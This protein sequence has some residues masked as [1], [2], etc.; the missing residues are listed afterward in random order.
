MNEMIR[1]TRRPAMTVLLVSLTFVAASSSVPAR[2]GDH[3]DV[4]Q[5]GGERKDKAKNEGSK[6]VTPANDVCPGGDLDGPSIL[7]SLPIDRASLL[8]DNGAVPPGVSQAFSIIAEIAVERARRNGLALVKSE[9]KKAVC[10][11]KSEAVKNWLAHLDPN[12]TRVLPKSCDLIST[13]DIEQLAG[14]GDAVRAALA[15]DLS[16]LLQGSL[17]NTNPDANSPHTVIQPA[18]RTAIEIAFDV[19]K[20]RNPRATSNTAWL[21][22]DSILNANWTGKRCSKASQTTGAELCNENFLILK[23]GLYVARVYVALQR[24]NEKKTP[25]VG[26]LIRTCVLAR[27]TDDPNGIVS[28]KEF[29]TRHP[30]K[31]QK[32]ARWATLAADAAT[33]VTNPASQPDTKQRLRDSIDL[34]LEAAADF[35]EGGEDGKKKLES[36]RTVIDAALDGNYATVIAEIAK[37]EENRLLKSCADLG[38]AK[39]QADCSRQ[40]AKVV[41]LLGAVASYAGTYEGGDASSS[42]PAEAGK[43]ARARRDERKAALEGLIDA[44]TSRVNR[45]H[46]WVFSLGANL[47]ALALGKQD[48]RVKPAGGGQSQDINTQLSLPLG[49]A[50]QFLPRGGDGKGCG[51][52]FGFHSMLT[53]V[54]IGQ[55][56]AWEKKVGTTDPEWKTLA[57]PG[58]Q[59][60]V[61]W[62]KP[63]NFFTFGAQALYA[64]DLF[65]VKGANGPERTGGLRYGV[66]LQYF[67]PL[68]DFN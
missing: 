27:T 60:G 35:T 16:R 44:T 52:W 17:D 64:P 31:V 51:K 47:G 21:V 24:D 7:K 45:G 34:I 29:L 4:P 6:T 26:D 38:A 22:L 32:L 54:D 18:V 41:A 49:L 55:Y 62:G 28:L 12:D 39:V 13:S 9:L 50:F 68:F 3:Q 56:V 14:Q 61:I 15:D 65:T 66:T 48:L 58:L 59:L 19:L 5:V 63:D 40:R 30:E 53:L 1:A 25:T 23:G 67:I 43:Q 36:I 33:A 20:Q 8:A 37:S 57:A 11:W 46:E 2:S 10:D 42:D